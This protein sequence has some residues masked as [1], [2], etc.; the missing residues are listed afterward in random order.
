MTQQK[1][2]LKE[3]LKIV[4]GVAIGLALITFVGMQVLINVLMGLDHNPPPVPFRILIGLMAG[5]IFGVVI[6]LWGYVY[7]D[8]KRRGMNPLLWLLVAILV[9]NALGFIVYFLMR[10]EL[11][12]QCP[13]CGATVKSGFNFCPKC[14]F[15]LAPVCPQ[16][17]RATNPG[18]VYCPHC[19]TKLNVEPKQSAMPSN[20]G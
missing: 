19:G 20:A 8:A 10:S 9:P 1:F 2:Q 18:D 6:L 3:E 12:E 17:H 7:R 14:N 16:C 5:T 15:E 4:P 11:V 13:H